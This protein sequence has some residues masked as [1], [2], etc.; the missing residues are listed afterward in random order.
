[1]DRVRSSSYLVRYRGRCWEQVHVVSQ[2]ASQLRCGPK[3]RVSAYW[4]I[5]GGRAAY[6]HVQDTRV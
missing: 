1:M 4:M 3:L 2:A 5:C 6:F